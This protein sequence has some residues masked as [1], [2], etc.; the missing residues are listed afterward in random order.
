MSAIAA[1]AG[2]DEVRRWRPVAAYALLAASTQLLWLT[3]APLTTASAHR[4]HVSEDAIGLL[5]EIFPLLYVV[6]AVPAGRLLDRSFHR[7]LATGAV[8]TAAGGLIRLIGLDFAWALIG[9]LLVASGQ[10][11]VLNAVT[12][13][14]AEHL[15]PRLRP[16][17][18]AAVS[19]AVFA[20]MLLA[21]VLG[22]IF[23]GAHIP[24]L[25]DVQAVFAVIAAAAML[26]ELRRHGRAG[27]EEAAAV[28]MTAV[29]EVWAERNVR[30][31]CGL[32]FLGF[33]VFIALTTWLQALLQNYRVSST[34][35]GAL[36]VAM[37]LTGAVGAASLPPLV[38]RWRA[39]RRTV[40]AAVAVAAA[41]GLVLAF[42]HAIAVDAVVLIAIG[43][44]LLTLLPVILELSE[45]RG[46]SSAGT[47]TALLWL[48]GNAGGLVVA[49]VVAVLVHHPTPAFLIL[50][51]VSL[52]ATPLVFALS[53]DPAPAAAHAPA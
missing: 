5:A 4:Y 22:T 27:G 34:T 14:A 39:E 24:A 21:L 29:R 44:L 45:R 38:V 15:P 8:L 41:G 12:K 35:A 49:V 33:G 26:Y 16:H 20:G 30:V 23:G 53:A 18:I 42:E 1:A 46:G 36:L 48:A 11:L 52:L 47:V 2:R 50:A 3:Y 37:V 51:F 40:G 17:G 32:L 9:Q 10:P 6:L 43:L 25:L 28:A 7:W 31:L 19:A 13:V